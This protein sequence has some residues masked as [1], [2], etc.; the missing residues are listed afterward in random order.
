[1]SYE[2]VV[3]ERDGPIGLVT[4]ARARQLNALSSG[5]LGELVDALEAHDGDDEVRVIILT[6]GPDVFAAG[7]DLK[8]FSSSTMVDLLAGNRVALFDRVR[9]IDKP[10]VAAVSGYALGGGCELAM[11]CDMIV[12]SE[13]ARFGQPEINVG[14]MPGAGGSQRLTRTIGK[15]KAMEM[16]LTGAPIDAATAEQLGLV[17]KVVPVANLM[18]EAKALALKI[19]A[20]APLAVRLAKQAVLKAYE[21]PLS[22]AVD[23]ERKLFYLLFATEDAREGISAFVEKRTPQ[24]HGR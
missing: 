12:A 24:F 9:T 22:E 19:A 20:K 3:S 1:M 13:T 21:L 18:D 14:I 16:V 8:E 17:N 4:L 5:V 2:Y 15:A 11:L 7:A 6:G 23:L 10:I